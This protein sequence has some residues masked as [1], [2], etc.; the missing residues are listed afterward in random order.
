M[1]TSLD[2]WKQSTGVIRMKLK[3]KFINSCI[4]KS[5]NEQWSCLQ[6]Q[7]KNILKIITRMIKV[8]YIRFSKCQESIDLSRK[9]KTNLIMLRVQSK[10]Q[11]LGISL[12]KSSLSLTSFLWSSE[13]VVATSLVNWYCK[14]QSTG[15]YTSV[16]VR[17]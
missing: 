17:F 15:K 2:I 11:C 10:M 3:Y 4:I 5:I 1:Y 7:N 6:S 16:C 12:E 14:Q 8:Y 13:M 9:F